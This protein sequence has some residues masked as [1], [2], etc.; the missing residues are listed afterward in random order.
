MAGAGIIYV[1]DASKPY[2]EEYEAEMEIHFAGQVSRLW[3]CL[4]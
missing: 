4:I 3:H 2:G 1:V